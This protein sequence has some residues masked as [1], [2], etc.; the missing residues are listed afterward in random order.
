[1][2]GFLSPQADYYEKQSVSIDV[3]I[4][5]RADFQ[6]HRRKRFNLYINKLNIPQ[7]FWRNARILEVGPAAGENALVLALEGANFSFVEPCVHLIKKLKHNFK[8]FKVQDRI[9]SIHQTV[10]ED[11]QTDEIFDAVIAE[12][13]L[14]FLPERGRELEKLALR[15]TDKGGLFF[16]AAKNPFGSFL[17]H[18]K[19]TVFRVAC[20]WNA[21]ESEADMV[22]LAHRMLSD[23][24]EKIPH[25]RSFIGY[26]KDTYLAPFHWPSVSW[27][28]D[29]FIHTM[30]SCGFY[31]YSSWP[32]YQE[33]DDLTW[34]KHVQPREAAV[35]LESYQRRIPCFFMG[36][37]GLP[38]L[39]P[40]WTPKRGA[41]FGERVL[42]LQQWL[43]DVAVNRMDSKIG[44]ETIL[45]ELCGTS[46]ELW[47]DDLKKAQLFTELK[48]IFL[49]LSASGDGVSVDELIDIYRSSVTVRSTWGMPYHYSVWHRKW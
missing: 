38:P 32:N 11:F 1:M 2:S 31:L 19:V 33:C 18:L 26:I 28:V 30:E 42:E 36:G 21:C 49:F 41:E 7:S 8:F 15:V 20:R 3:P 10:L 5:S 45:D 22:A 27:G 16:I 12:G 29:S 4:L 39:N 44:W 43:A 23:D 17:E 13:I 6:N 14:H 35:V 46:G 37:D 24:F 9:A 25:S 47:R 48:S 34:H 40:G